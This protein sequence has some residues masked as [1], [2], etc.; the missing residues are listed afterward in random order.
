MTNRTRIGIQVWNIANQ[1]NI[2]QTTVHEIIDS[3]LSYCKEQLLSGFRVDFFGLVSIVPDVEL[4]RYDYTLAYECE[5][6]ANMLKL[7][8][9]TV[10]VVIDA[11]ITDAINSVKSGMVAE[12][13]GLV[14]VKPLIVGDE[15]AKVHSSISQSLKL[16]L[17]YKDSPVTS[18]RV[19]T[20]KCLRDS[21]AK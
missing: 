16:L 6:V 18:F 15:I 5:K 19:H 3:Y 7:P 21:L 9:Y 11:Y 1:Y 13:R 4:S 10:F 14:S 8:Q 20:Y 2:T 12:L 17:P